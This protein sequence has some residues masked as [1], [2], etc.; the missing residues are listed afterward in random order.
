MENC[1]FPSE[2]PDAGTK[3]PRFLLE[4]YDI[5]GWLDAYVP[6]HSFW[7]TPQLRQYCDMEGILE[8]VEH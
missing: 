3:L 6:L 4:S 5:I 7:E 8:E 2:I 1:L